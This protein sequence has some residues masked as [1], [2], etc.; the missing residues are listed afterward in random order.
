MQPAAGLACAARTDSLRAVPVRDGELRRPDG[1]RIA[2][3]VTGDAGPWLLLCNG[4]TTTHNFWSRAV[5][6]WPNRR[7]IQWDYPGHGRSGPAETPA[8][9]HMPGL[10]DT[11][12]ALLEALDVERASLAGFSMGS[13]V[14]LLSALEHPDRFDAVVSVLGPAGR[15]FDTALWGVGGKTF[16][17]LIRLLRGPTVH[18]LHSAVSL[19][20]LTPATYAVGRLL[21]LYGA[22]TSK[23]DVRT[24][25]A[26]MRTLHAPTLREMLL[27]AG[28]LDLGPRLASLEPPLLIL[29]GERDAFAPA[30][31]VGRPMKEDA[32]QAEL[33]VL[34]EGT[35]GSLFGHASVIASAIDRFLQRHAV[36][37]QID[38][39][40]ADLDSG[41]R[42]PMS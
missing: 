21:A 15:L 22:E 38:P 27:S 2:Y 33:V 20:T 42:D 19:A 31:T 28:A 30:A 24:I 35:H 26:H 32:P 10:V 34:R 40:G 4:V 29:T 25:T 39:A 41:T 16:E 11:C 7:V 36:T 8:S 13:Q 17:A 9:A 1:T 23:Q 14:A 18:L 12:L 5:S 37:G 3:R 6:R